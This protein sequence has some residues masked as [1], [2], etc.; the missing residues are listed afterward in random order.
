MSIS[1]SLIVIHTGIQTTKFMFVSPTKEFFFVAPFVQAMTY[2]SGILD[3]DD[4][5]ATEEPVWILGKQY[6]ALYG[7]CSVRLQFD[8]S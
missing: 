5:P 1:G 4:F 2:E 6:S 7:M 8:S 3:Y